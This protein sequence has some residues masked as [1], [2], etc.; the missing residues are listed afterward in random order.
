[1]P[2]PAERRAN[3]ATRGWPKSRNGVGATAGSI[4]ISPEESGAL[5]NERDPLAA[6]DA[7][8]HEGVAAVDPLQLI[9]GLRRDQRAGR[10]DRMAEG[11]AGAI[12][13]HLG[14]VE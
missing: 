9:D 8:R 12:G 5:Q 10:A 11:D 14:R 6:A 2:V 13:V 3:S 7:H 1:M 4:M